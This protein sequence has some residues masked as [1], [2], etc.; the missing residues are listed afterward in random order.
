MNKKYMAFILLLT[1]IAGAT[2]ITA[3]QTVVL[4]QT[5]SVYDFLGSLCRTVVALC[6]PVPGGGGS[7]G[8]G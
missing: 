5:G 6:D 3:T 2:Y 7:G 1:L 4:N 8:F